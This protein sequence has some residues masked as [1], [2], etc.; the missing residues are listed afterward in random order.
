MIKSL[1]GIRGIAALIVALY[2]LKI[3]VD[4][5]S[6]IRNGYLFVDLFFVLSGFVMYAS[7]ASSISTMA[8]LRPFLVRRI[9]RLV[10]LLLFSTLFFVLVANAIVVAKRV[11]LEAGY[12]SVLHSPE[13]ANFLIPAASEIIATLTLTHGM[14][15]FD[16]LILNTPSWSISVEFYAYVLF[17]A[18]CILLMAKARIAA[19]VA[20]SAIGFVVSVWASVSIHDCLEQKGCL[21]LTYDFAFPRAVYAF[22]LG[23]LVASFSGAAKRN[24]E[25]LQL[26]ALAVLT[27]LLLVVD[28]HP[29]VS[30][31]FPLVFAVL[32]LSI[33]H[34]G[35]F[36]SYFLKPRMLQIL[37][38]RSYSVYLMH[39]PLLLLFE[40][41]VKRVDGIALSIAVLLL[42]VAVLVVV[43]GWTYRFIE[44]PLRIR[45]NRL[46]SQL[47]RSSSSQPMKMGELHEHSP[48][49]ADRPEKT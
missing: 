15:V 35:G 9:G 40:N 6:L 37:G 23:A 8:D 42:Y 43:S 1:E 4:H 26:P 39:M 36:I 25:T 2:H 12:A 34:D 49:S 18:L 7:Y 17:A 32:I 20:F 38:Q 10:P 47:S 13:Q 16:R 48:I 22:F 28:A 24:F 29:V 21:S 5:F 11:A 30:F 41:L 44:D 27:F 33:G 14:G 46:A 31:F 3:G 19:F 45:F